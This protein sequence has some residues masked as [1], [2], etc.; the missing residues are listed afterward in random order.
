[1]NICSCY[2]IREN[3]L[4]KVKIFKISNIIT[5]MIP[6]LIESL[7][8]KCSL[9]IICFELGKRLVLVKLG[10]DQTML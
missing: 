3:K 9:A 8:N 6:I 10:I 1:M 4:Y 2:C 5:L 7:N